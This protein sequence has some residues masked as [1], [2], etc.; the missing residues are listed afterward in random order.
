VKATRHPTEKPLELIEKLINVATV[1]GEVVLDSFA[2]VATTCV[3]A[4]N[5]KRAYIGIEME[6]KYWRL[7]Q[8]RLNDETNEDTTG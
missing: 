1:E 8:G 2:G 7:G 5:T 4:K 3:A 6:E